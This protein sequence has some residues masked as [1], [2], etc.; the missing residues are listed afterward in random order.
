MPH[1]YTFKYTIMVKYLVPF[2]GGANSVAA[3]LWTLKQNVIPHMVYIT[4]LF[5]QNGPLEQESILKFLQHFRDYWGNGLRTWNAQTHKF[6]LNLTTHTIPAEPLL[7][8]TDDGKRFAYLAAFCVS[9]AQA[10]QCEAVVCA[11]EALA[12]VRVPELEKRSHLSF[13]TPNFSGQNSLQYL[14]SVYCDHLNDYEDQRSRDEQ[15]MFGDHEAP[16][17]AICRFLGHFDEDFPLF[18]HLQCCLKPRQ[19]LRKKDVLP[20]LCMECWRCQQ[21]RRFITQ[22]VDDYMDSMAPEDWET[23]SEKPV[24]DVEPPTKRRRV[25]V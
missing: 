3:L 7:T 20:R 19:E 13:L 18:E 16:D 4:N 21:V 10:L 1:S 12:E 24:M 23:I 11:G 15:D 2:T 14:Y 25:A 8:L 6:E 9:R 17:P 5:P 22:N